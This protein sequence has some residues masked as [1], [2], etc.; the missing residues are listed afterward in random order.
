MTITRCPH[1]TT[2]YENMSKR[3]LAFAMFDENFSCRSEGWEE[4]RRNALKVCRATPIKE[5]DNIDN[6]KL[7]L[8]HMDELLKDPPSWVG[9]SNGR[10][11]VGENKAAVIRE[12][13]SLG[14][15]GPISEEFHSAVIALCDYAGIK[16]SWNTERKLTSL[17]VF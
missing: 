14:S 5:D 12:L 9:C 6:H 8:A 7:V 16:N 3:D 17:G 15:I 11:V 10:I 13:R 2:P 1:D 4:R